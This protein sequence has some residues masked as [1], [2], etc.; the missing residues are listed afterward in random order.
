MNRSLLKKG[1]LGLVALLVLIQLIPLGWARTNPP[2]LSE[3]DWPSPEVRALAER[4]CFD[5]HSNETKWPW[6][7]KVAPASWLVI[8]DTHN[9]RRHL[10]FSEW[11]QGGR[12]EG[13]RELVGVVMEGEMPPVLYTMMQPQARLTPEE[14]QILIEGLRQLH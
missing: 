14:R 8:L 12:G 1:I 2:V 9:G 13:A 4:A 11:N 6:Y 7:S 3:P 5:C 10:N